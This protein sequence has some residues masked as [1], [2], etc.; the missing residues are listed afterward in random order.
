[1]VINSFAF[2]ITQKELIKIEM[3]N[4]FK[5]IFPFLF[6]KEGNKVKGHRP[7]DDNEREFTFIWYKKMQMGDT[8]YYTQPFRT[9]VR[10][11]T[12]DD[13]SKKVEDFALRKMTLVIREEKDYDSSDLNKINKQF[14]EINKN[15]N[16]VF[17][18]M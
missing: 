5:N 12:R 11:K 14:D 3:K 18:S 17:D 15:M 13:A 16:D 6:K 1:M 8:T 2:S 4:F 9:K 7:P 10:A